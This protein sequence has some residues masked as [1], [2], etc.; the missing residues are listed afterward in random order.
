[1]TKYFPRG[2]KAVLPAIAL[3]GGLTVAGAA[4]AHGDGGHGG[5]KHGAWMDEMFSNMDTNSDGMVSA[6][7]RAA[8][9]QARSTAADSN[10]DGKLSADEMVA[11]R[12]AKMTDRIA[13]FVAKQDQ[14]GDGALSFDEMP[15]RGARMMKK[16]YT[17]NDGAID[18]AELEAFKAHMKD[19]K[20]H[21]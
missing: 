19:R 21:D 3:L 4:F 13:A 2:R 14:N 18:K 10:G 15:Y 11:A 1:M 8:F 12:Q 16:I 6:E 17:N 9:K 7:E 5:G 20:G